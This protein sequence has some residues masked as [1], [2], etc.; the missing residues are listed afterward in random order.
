MY[1]GIA[2]SEK[3]MDMHTYMY[4]V[5]SVGSSSLYLVICYWVGVDTW[6][7]LGFKGLGLGKTGN[8]VGT[9][10]F[11]FPLRYNIIG[12]AWPVFLLSWLLSACRQLSTGSGSGPWSM[13][14]LISLLCEQL[15][16]LF[17]PRSSRLNLNPSLMA[18]SLA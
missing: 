1:A 8:N 9:S 18:K 2:L 10:V 5:T 4:S 11:E 6:Y 14:Y 16:V 12:I 13:T 3:Y 15:H 17:H 7:E